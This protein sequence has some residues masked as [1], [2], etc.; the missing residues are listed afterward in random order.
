MSFGEAYTTR[1]RAVPEPAPLETLYAIQREAFRSDPYPPPKERKLDLRRLENLLLER[2]EELASAIGADFNGRCRQEVIFSEILLSIRALRHARKRV[3]AWMA[4]RPRE[5][6]WPLQPAKAWVFPQPLGVVGIISPWNYP[7]M[8]TIAP[9][10]GALA[11]GNRVL[12]KLSEFTPGTSAALAKLIADTFP[13]DHVA[14]V[15]GDISVGRAFAALPFDH[16]LFTGSTNAGREVMRAAADNL[17]PVTLELGGKSPAIVAPDADLK[18][19]AEDIAYGKLLNAGQTCIAPDYVLVPGHILEA[20]VA[21]LRQSIEGYWPAPANN[22]EY[23]AI[24]NERHL[25]RLEGY[26]QEARDRGAHVMTVGPPP[27]LG[28][29]RLP[30]TLVLN[31]PEDIALMRDEIFGP[32]LPILPYERIE[33]AIAY[34]NR[35]PRPLALY[36]FARSGRTIEAVLARTVT[37]AACV[38]DT[39]VYIVAEDLPFGGVGASGFGRYHGR[40]GF[41]TFSHLKPVFRRKVPGLSRFLRPP[42]GRMHELLKRILIG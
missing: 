40:E 1:M 22:P 21:A 33:E 32:I 3:A 23:T 25:S 35:H 27:E 28:S 18:A 19:A 9:L 36:L 16:L 26:I 42:Y 24:I 38:N 17:T 37:G 5:L 34:V 39:L 11:A 7:A 12:L 20:F 30:P 13:V 8:L 41:D 4:P 10:A 31:P 29:R 2:Q 15:Q 14:A 6:D